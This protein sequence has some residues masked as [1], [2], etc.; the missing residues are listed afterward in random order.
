M[1]KP[2]V[3]NDVQDVRRANLLALAAQWG[4]A[5][6]LAKRMKWSGPSYVSQ[7]TSGHR[8][9]TEKTARHIEKVLDLEPQWLDTKHDVQATPADVDET[10]VR[11]VVLMV[12][13]VL[14][15]EGLTLE[16]KKFAELVEIVYE[17]AARS[18][19]IDEAY[20]R[21]VVNLMK[22]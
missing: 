22:G 5:S 21:K 13:G 17:D 3:T 9:I 4:G 8:P 20:A 7:L 19:R 6:G 11:R 12:G 18:G 10:L 16:P 15:D 1:K 2:L 14:Q